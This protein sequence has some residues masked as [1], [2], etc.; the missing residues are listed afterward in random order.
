MRRVKSRINLKRGDLTK[1]MDIWSFLNRF[2]D[3]WSSR[4]RMEWQ[5]RFHYHILNTYL[6]KGQFTNT[7]ETTKV[8]EVKGNCVGCCKK[9]KLYGFL[10]QVFCRCHQS[11]QIVQSRMKTGAIFCW[12]LSPSLLHRAIFCS[13]VS[14]HFFTKV[15]K[16]ISG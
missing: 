16:A 14:A 15:H 13:K 3:Q 6:H 10:M 9:K 8:N 7:V 1:E 12:L 4:F 2:V 11:W 5:N